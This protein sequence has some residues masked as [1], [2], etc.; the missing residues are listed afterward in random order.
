MYCINDRFFD[1][2]EDVIEHIIEVEDKELEDLPDD[3]TIE[4]ECCNHEPI[5]QLDSSSLYDMLVNNFEERSSEDGEEW[6]G[7]EEILKKHIDFESL[8][9][10]IPKLWF[11]NGRVEIYSKNQLIELNK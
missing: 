3:Y 4:V 11:P 1:E 2:I 7:I 10:R 6:G 9:K 5:F 8:N